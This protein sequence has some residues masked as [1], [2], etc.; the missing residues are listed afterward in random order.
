MTG[1]IAVLKLLHNKQS[2][3]LRINK[4]LGFSL[5]SCLIPSL[6]AGT[7]YQSVDSKGNIN[8]VKINTIGNKNTYQGDA[9][10]DDE[11]QV[12]S[13][14]VDEFDQLLVDLPIE[15]KYTK[16]T[17][18][19]KII[20]Q[21]H[22]FKAINLD[23]Q[24]GLL[25]LKA[26]SFSTNKEVIVELSSD[27]LNQITVLS[28][29][30]VEVRNLTEKSLDV[31]LQD[32]STLFVQGQ[33]DTCHLTIEDASSLNSRNLN[34]SSIFIQANGSSSV[35]A[36]TN[37]LIEGSLKDAVDLTVFGGPRSRKLQLYDVA[38]VS[39]E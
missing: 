21:P 35:E 1:L 32:A 14:S 24:E 2:L 38:D 36:Y 15:I 28:S 29:A 31:S 19:L 4:L 37:Y 22:V 34:C 27:H 17:P 25:S 30:S 11:A 5:L 16:G 9:S 39:Y 26:G 10:N 12:Y 3:T 8:Q 7:S 33:V 6:I 20:A 23:Q 18:A 13:I